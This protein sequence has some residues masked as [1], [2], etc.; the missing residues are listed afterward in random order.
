MSRREFCFDGLVGPTHNYSGLSEGNLA[1]TGHRSQT[2]NP[3]A[4]ALEGLKKIQL[5]H[6]L[7][8]GQAVLPPHERPSIAHLKRLGFSGS[9]TEVLARAAKQAP[10]ILSSVSSASAMWTANA[11]TVTAS[12]DTADGKVHFTAANLISKFH[13]SIEP[14]ATSAVLRRIFSDDKHF[15]HHDPLQ[16]HE[17]FADEGSAN[18]TRLAASH[19][20]RGLHLFVYGRSQTEPKIG[21]FV[22]R[23]T[24]EASQA[25]ARLHGIAD[26]QLILARQNPA[27]IDAGVFHNDV[28]SVGN[29]NLF[30]FHEACFEHED[31]VLAEIREKWTAL[32]AGPLTLMRVSAKEVPIEDAVR[33]YLF[34]SQLVTL[35]S[36]LMA[37]IAPQECQSTPSVA[38]Y[39]EN[40]IASKGPIR[41]VHYPQVRESM[42]NGGGPACLRLRVVLTEQERNRCSPDIFIDDKKQSELEG[43]VTKH[44]R[45][46]LEPGDLADPKLLVESRT[47]L[48]EL[49]GL[50]GLGSLYPFQK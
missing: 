10:W 9:D 16:P 45:D 3:R 33:S 37:L 29:E 31:A 22:A 34:N 4:A 13:R 43:W 42:R 41:E 7:G 28:I 11:A 44:Y 17:M 26:A 1:S 39:L 27:A 38:A 32:E 47:A 25:I 12:A 21:R 19:S 30:F 2:S 23:Q 18:H 40:L 15:V 20:D 49:T 24:R 50:L 14:S 48:D 6:R 36:G 8:I 35:P 46:R 5:L